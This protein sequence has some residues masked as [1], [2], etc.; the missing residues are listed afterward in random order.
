MSLLRSAG[1]GIQFAVAITCKTFEKR[2]PPVNVVATK[3]Q[4]VKV[5]FEGDNTSGTIVPTLSG[6]KNSVTG[7]KGKSKPRKSPALRSRSPA[8]SGAKTKAVS[9]PVKAK[10]VTTS[11]KKSKPASP[12]KEKKRKS[13]TR[14]AAK[15]AK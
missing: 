12:K 11:V 3:A 4:K 9:S 5:N 13:P 6:K 8:R 7:G 10:S 14:T 2:Q 15:K 1:R